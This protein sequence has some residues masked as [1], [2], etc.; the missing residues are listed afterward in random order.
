MTSIGFAI[1]DCF[2]QCL[3]V[4]YS[5]YSKEKRILSSRD[6]YILRKLFGW[7]EMVFTTEEELAVELQISSERVRQLKKRA[8]KRLRITGQKGNTP[9]QM[10][11]KI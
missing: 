6:V 8:L 4:K 5:K 10:A 1:L 7:E 2:T 3:D 11:A 9:V